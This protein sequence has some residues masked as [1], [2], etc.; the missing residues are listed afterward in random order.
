MVIIS[1]V[2]RVDVTT[3][4]GPAVHGA[5]VRTTRNSPTWIDAEPADAIGTVK[6]PC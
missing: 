1:T 4:R 2:R 3:H 5:V 6:L